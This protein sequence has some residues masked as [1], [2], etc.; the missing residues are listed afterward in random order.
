MTAG[1]PEPRPAN[2][3]GAAGVVLAAAEFHPSQI[4][5]KQADGKALLRVSRLIHIKAKVTP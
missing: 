5:R 4:N 1:R 2:D 3:A